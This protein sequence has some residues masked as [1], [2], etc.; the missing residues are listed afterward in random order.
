MDTMK[1]KMLSFACP[2]LSKQLIEYV[3]LDAEQFPRSKIRVQ[4]ILTTPTIRD[5]PR[6]S[7]DGSSTGQASIESSERLL[8]PAQ[9]WPHPFEHGWLVFCETASIQQNGKIVFDTTRTSC[10]DISHQV[11]STM[12]FGFEQECFFEMMDETKITPSIWFEQKGR[13]SVVKSSADLQSMKNYCGIGYG[14]ERPVMMEFMRLSLA[15]GLH[16]CGMNQEVAPS[17]WEFQVGPGIGLLMADELNVAR[18]LLCRVAEK[19]GWRVTYHPKPRLSGITEMMGWN[20]SGCHTNISTLEMRT[21]PQET[22]TIPTLTPSQNPNNHIQSL[23]TLMKRDHRLFMEACS[24]RDNQERM[25]GQNETATYDEF[26][27][28]LRTRNTSIRIPHDMIMNGTGYMED[29]RPGANM[30]PYRIV[31]RYWE[32]AI[33][34]QNSQN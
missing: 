7:Y 18:W 34:S 25:T 9:F 6:W 2:Q 10:L 5:F 20:G 33:Q 32:Y 24:G 4:S 31:K 28:G 23:L 26:T 30:D 22:Q 1:Y 8:I 13:K 3:W 15:M 16:V 27:V 14:E 21:Q 12:W 11:C 17:Q 19:R 29:R